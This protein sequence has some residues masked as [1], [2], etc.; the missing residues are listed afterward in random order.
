MP[1]PTVPANGEAM[2]AEGRS[3][4]RRRFFLLVGHAGAAAA[5][6]ATLANGLKA[7]AAIAGP[8]SDPALALIEEHRRAFAYANERGTSEEEC[9][10]RVDLED[11]VLWRLA[12]TEPTTIGGARALLEHIADYDSGC[13]LTAELHC[14]AMSSVAAA[15]AKMEAAHP[16]G[17]E[18]Y[19]NA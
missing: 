10:R 19:A 14:A 16:L 13:M 7:T 17:D 3:A 6:T 1:N 9:G 8:A 18:E 4:S 11:E 12:E 5:A 2:P 15:L